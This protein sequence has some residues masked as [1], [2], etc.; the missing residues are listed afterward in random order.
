MD[1]DFL[2]KTKD[3]PLAALTRQDLDP[4][5]QDELRARIATLEAEIGRT[6]A[7]LAE[8]GSVKSAADALFGRR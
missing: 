8:A 2:P 5:S 1:D 4:L 7:K 3:D 6:R